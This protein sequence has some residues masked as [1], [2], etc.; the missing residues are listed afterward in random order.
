MTICGATVIVLSKGEQT[1]PP[2]VGEVIDQHRI[3]RIDEDELHVA[4]VSGGMR[5]YRYEE[6]FPAVTAAAS[7]PFR[8]PIPNQVRN[9][10]SR[11]TADADPAEGASFAA[12][13]NPAP[14]SP[15]PQCR[16]S[17]L[18]AHHLAR[19]TFCSALGQLGHQCLTRG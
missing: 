14:E 3:D 6:H 13:K 9:R 19:T 12:P 8:D 1:Y 11:D 17:L 2:T 7:A 10:R 4:Y 18:V 15:P 16:I 5:I